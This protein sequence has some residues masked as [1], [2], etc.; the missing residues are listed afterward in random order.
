MDASFSCVSENDLNFQNVLTIAAGVF[1]VWILM[2]QPCAP[3]SL[4]LFEVQ[5]WSEDNGEFI[6]PKHFYEKRLQGCSRNAGEQLPAVPGGKGQLIRCERVVCHR[7][8]TAV[9][10]TENGGFHFLHFLLEMLKLKKNTRQTHSWWKLKH[11]LRYEGGVGGR[12]YA[13]KCQS[14]LCISRLQTRAIVSCPV[15]CWWLWRKA[16]DAGLTGEQDAKR[17]AGRSSWPV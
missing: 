8:V 15:V 16:A 3:I 14:S 13:Q 12:F 6:F 1:I 7:S 11:W 2:G 17:S 9:A 5:T 4:L 10:T